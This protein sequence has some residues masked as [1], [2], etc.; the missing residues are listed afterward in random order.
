MPYVHGQIS[1][2]CQLI[3]VINAAIHYGLLPGYNVNSPNHGQ[4]IRD[5]D[6]DFVNLNHTSLLDVF[7][8]KMRPIR[9]NKDID[10]IRGRIEGILD[11]GQCLMAIMYKEKVGWHA[12]LIE[13]SVEDEGKL[14]I[15]V[16]NTQS[17]FQKDWITIDQL[18]KMLQRQPKLPSNLAWCILQPVS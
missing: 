13:S 7:K 11:R 9:L 17:I 12:F 3:A 15:H 16:L 2:E 18:M 1:E 8:L 14:W 4:L 10:N 5:S 6:I